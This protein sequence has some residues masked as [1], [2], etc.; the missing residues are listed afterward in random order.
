[1]RG[2]IPV[3]YGPGPDHA[4]VIHSMEYR[5]HFLNKHPV[6][7]IAEYAEKFLLFSR[8]KRYVQCLY[9][10]IT[11]LF[12]GIKETDLFHQFIEINPYSAYLLIL[13]R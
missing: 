13:F 5:H 4:A 12:I 6:A 1:M 8:A 3:R 11:V 10:Q 7:D 9:I 2:A